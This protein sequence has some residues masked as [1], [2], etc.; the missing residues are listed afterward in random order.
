[1]SDPRPEG[2]KLSC[3]TASIKETKYFCDDIIE[4]V[5][6]HVNLALDT[7]PTS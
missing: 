4:R 6:V 7:T 5:R 2:E 1:M 3:N